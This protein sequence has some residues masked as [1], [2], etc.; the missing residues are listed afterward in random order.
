[1]KTHILVALFICNVTFPKSQ[2][3]ASTEN[4]LY[5]TSINYKNNT[6]YVYELDKTCLITKIN[7]T[8]NKEKELPIGS[9]NLYLEYLL[10]GKESK[11]VI[12]PIVA[13]QNMENPEMFDNFLKLCSK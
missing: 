12:S 10:R 3:K 13:K 7:P 5:R 6:Y 2:N 11:K 4:T 8:S 1:M 9:A